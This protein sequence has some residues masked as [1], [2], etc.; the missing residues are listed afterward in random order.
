MA[1]TRKRKTV[2]TS[3]EDDSDPIPKRHTP[4]VKSKRKRQKRDPAL[5]NFDGGCEVADTPED[6]YETLLEGTVG[7]APDELL[8]DMQN[9]LIDQTCI[10]DSIT[11]EAL[12]QALH[13]MPQETLF[14][15]V[16]FCVQTKQFDNLNFLLGTAVSCLLYHCSLLSQPASI[17]PPSLV[18][19]TRDWT[20]R[21]CWLLLWDR[22]NCSAP[23]WPL[24][25]RLNSVLITCTALPKPSVHLRPSFLCFNSTS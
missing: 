1:Y 4:S 19:V 23:S 22:L 2:S 24:L 18:F 5:L 6:E 9:A 7:T 12:V 11:E 17:R 10:A 8:V 13:D 25:S 3:C 15:F 20:P 16:N 14:K 21:C